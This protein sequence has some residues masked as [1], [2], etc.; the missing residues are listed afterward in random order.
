M[1]PEHPTDPG[2]PFRLPIE[3][4]TDWLSAAAKRREDREP[5]Y[6]G[7]LEGLPGCSSGTA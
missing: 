3:T 4:T 2:N 5:W 7:F 1:S 6:Y